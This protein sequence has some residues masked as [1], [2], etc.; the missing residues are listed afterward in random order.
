LQRNLQHC[1][2][3]LRP[4]TPQGQP[5][6]IALRKPL[7]RTGLK[8]PPARV[9]PQGTEI[10]LLEKA[11]EFRPGA[12]K[13]PIDAFAE[14][15]LG[16]TGRLLPKQGQP[17]TFGR[18]ASIK[19][20]VKVQRFSE[21]INGVP[22]CE[23]RVS[24]QRLAVNEKNEPDPR[25]VATLQLVLPT[26]QPELIA[27]RDAATLRMTNLLADLKT[28]QSEAGDDPEKQKSYEEAWKRLAK[29]VDLPSQ[30]DR[31]LIKVKAEKDADTLKTMIESLN[32]TL[33]RAEPDAAKV[34]AIRDQ[35]DWVEADVYRIVQGNDGQSIRVLVTARERR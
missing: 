5:R 3:E 13:P 10:V 14:L 4:R 17:Y 21:P 30:K 8:K 9:A 26:G 18:G 19:P 16:E 2:V 25:V 24:T 32:E 11:M 7:L 31:G 29:A 35:I 6:Y 28:V 20:P 22:R 34:A 1:V 12:D 15:Y 33:A 27:Q 23:L